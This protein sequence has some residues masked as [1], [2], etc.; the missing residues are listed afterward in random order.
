MLYLANY[1][2]AGVSCAA[3]LFALGWPGTVSEG[4]LACAVVALATVALL[5]LAGPEWLAS[6]H[7]RRARSLFEQRSEISAIWPLAIAAFFALALL[8]VAHD[9]IAEWMS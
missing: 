2:T 7:R 8:E 3:A 1:L 9:G 6:W 5:Y 4:A